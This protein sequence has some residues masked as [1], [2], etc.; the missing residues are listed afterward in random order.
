M[1]DWITMR[2][3]CSHD[4]S[5]LFGGLVVSMNSKGE[6]EWQ[7]E[8][9]VV[10]EGSHSKNITIRSYTDTTIEISGNPV[11][12]LQGHNVFGTNDLV[13]LVNKTLDRLISLDLG[14]TPTQEELEKIRKGVFHLTRVDVNEH[15]AF[16]SEQSAKSYLR[17]IAN[18]ANMRHRGAGQFRGDTLYFSPQS[19]RSVG[20]IY[21]KGDEIHSR[22]KEHRLHDDF[23]AIPELVDYATKSLRL[24]LKILSTQLKE[25]E[26]H[27]GYNWT[28]ETP[29]YLLKKH[30][31]GKLELSENMPIQDT[32]LLS[33][34]THLRSSYALWEAGHDLKQL[35][36]KRTYHRHRNDLREY[37]IDIGIIQESKPQ[38]N[39][40][41]MIS[42]LEV[43]PMGIPLWAYEKG[44]V[45]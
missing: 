10:V 19:R 1:I 40:I 28:L 36:S 23:L 9:R 41:P 12:F 7:T 30:F 22:K 4:T 18:S 31:I 16:N 24:E 45:A 15:F 39:I 33:M 6:V 17:A 13:Y 14:L 8:K 25:W 44:L 21:H 37:G 43:V 5:K 38:N 26:L 35:L 29:Y 32:V 34:P 2:L 3:R 11:K 27:L 42:Y 20:K